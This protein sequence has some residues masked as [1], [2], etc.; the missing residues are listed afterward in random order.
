[1]AWSCRSNGWLNSGTVKLDEI[2]TSTNLNEFYIG[3]VVNDLGTDENLL[4]LCQI[5]CKMELKFKVLFSYH[6]SFISPADFCALLTDRSTV[7][8]I[9]SPVVGGII[10]RSQC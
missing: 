8:F 2:V 6:A 10:T 9:P 5:Y 1:M 4:Q 7:T 3:S